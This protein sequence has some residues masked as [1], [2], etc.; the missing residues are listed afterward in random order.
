[1]TCK[2]A[3]GGLTFYFRKS[4]GIVRNGQCCTMYNTRGVRVRWTYRRRAVPRC[5][6]RVLG[7]RV[8]CVRARAR[9][10]KSLEQCTWG[11][12]GRRHRATSRVKGKDFAFFFLFFFCGTHTDTR[13]KTRYDW[14]LIKDEKVV[15]CRV[16]IHP[17]LKVYIYYC[18]CVCVHANARVYMLRRR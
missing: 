1:M 6:C 4:R 17:P 13:S 9:S 15:A 10:N 14:S 2:N 3:F 5:C 18:E 12:K 8:L 16:S 11:I 7:C